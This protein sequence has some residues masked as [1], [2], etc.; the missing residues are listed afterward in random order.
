MKTEPGEYF[1]H[2]SSYI[3]WN[4]TITEPFNIPGTFTLCFYMLNM[5]FSSLSKYEIVS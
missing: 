4:L 2:K 1:V 3:P 5:Y